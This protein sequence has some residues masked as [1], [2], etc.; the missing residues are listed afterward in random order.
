MKRLTF[1]IFTSFVL[2]AGCNNKEETPVPSN[3]INYDFEEGVQGWSAGMSDFPSDWDP[4]KMEFAFEHTTLPAEVNE[5]G[6]A[7]MLSGRNGSDDLFLFIKKEITGLKANHTYSI[8][9]DIE[10]ASQYPTESFGIGGSPGSSVY[11]K[12]GGSTIEPKVVD[13]QGMLQ[14]NIDKGNQSQ[15][16]SNMNVIGNIGIPGEE[17]KYKLISRKN[18]NPIKVTTD[19][20]GSLWVIVGTDSGFEGTTTLYY[21]NISVRLHE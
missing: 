18:E 17:F 4:E 1:L 8:D 12:A 10:F 15:G 21:N 20:N 3:E 14:M 7:L 19:A 2:L 5:N 9:F 11:L 6:K 16:G 13:E